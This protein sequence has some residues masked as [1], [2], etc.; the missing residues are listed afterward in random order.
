[1]LV[2]SGEDFRI[3]FSLSAW[4][5]G[6]PASP[7]STRIEVE[8]SVGGPGSTVRT[9]TRASR[10]RRERLLHWRDHALVSSLCV[11]CRRICYATAARAEL[12]TRIAAPTKLVVQ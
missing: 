5:R 1:M 6:T 9:S 10:T 3:V 7:P 2:A 8:I 11:N 12:R 4:A